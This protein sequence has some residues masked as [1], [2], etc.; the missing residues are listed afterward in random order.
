MESLEN[1]KKF[2]DKVWSD[3]YRDIGRYADESPEFSNAMWMRTKLETMHM[4]F[5]VDGISF[6]D[7]EVY[8]SRFGVESDDDIISV[9]DTHLIVRTWDLSVPPFKA[10]FR[11]ESI[12]RP[13]LF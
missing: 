7:H 10:P 4:A 9:D 12:S 5:D 8:F 13:D 1:F 3:T 6:D 11:F 2:S